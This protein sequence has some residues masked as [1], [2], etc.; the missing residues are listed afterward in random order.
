M[1]LKEKIPTAQTTRETLE[2]QYDR[3]F[4]ADYGVGSV[5]YSVVGNQNPEHNP[6]LFIPGYTEGT[7]IV[8]DFGI[9]LSELG[10][11]QAIVLNQPDHR[12]ILKSLQGGNLGTKRTVLDHQAEAVLAVLRNMGLT[13]KP[14]DFITHSFG[15]LILQRA[16]ELADLRRIRVPFS[17]RKDA[18]GK[19]SH[20]IMIA[21]AGINPD[22]DF[23]SF[24]SRGAR[25]QAET[26]KGEKALDPDYLFIRKA[27]KAVAKN[28]AKYI[29]ELSPL[30]RKRIVFKKLGE[31]GLKPTV[32]TYANDPMYPDS[33]IG[34]NLGQNLRDLE[35]WTT[36]LDIGRARLGASYHNA[37]SLEEFRTKSGWRKKMAKRAWAHHYRNS[38]HNDLL[39]HPGRTAGA[40]LQKLDEG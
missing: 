5:E 25:F 12:S 27:F 11:R 2:G 32:L 9:T 15:S 26:F 18:D 29:R 24:M 17:S 35:G 13:D 4:K 19:R 20:S 30:M 38:G 6:I 8:R 33:V 28:P 7:E 40:V 16:A 31:F 37:G 1:A 34:E 21:P 22:E 36:P 23:K 14:I 39:F 10:D 3:P